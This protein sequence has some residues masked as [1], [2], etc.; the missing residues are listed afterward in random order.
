MADLGLGATGIADILRELTDMFDG[1]GV[2]VD[3]ERFSPLKLYTCLLSGATQGTPGCNVRGVWDG[4]GLSVAVTMLVEEFKRRA[5]VA[6]QSGKSREPA[7]AKAANPKAAKLKSKSKPK[8]KPKPKP[9]AAKPK[10]KVAKPKA[11]KPKAAQPKPKAKVAKPKAAKAKAKEEKKSESESE[12]DAKPLT[13]YGAV[14]QARAAGNFKGAAA[15]G[16]PL[17]EAARALMAQS[18]AANPRTKAVKVKAAKPKTKAKAKAK[19]KPKA[20]YN[21]NTNAGRLAKMPRVP[22]YPRY[23]RQLLRYWAKHPNDAARLRVLNED[24]NQ[25]ADSIGLDPS[26]TRLSGGDL[27]FALLKMLHHIIRTFTRGTVDDGEGFEP[28]SVAVG[29]C[30]VNTRVGEYG[31]DR[32]TLNVERVR[33]LPHRS[34]DVRTAVLMVLQHETVHLLQE[35]RLLDYPNIDQHEEEFEMYGGIDLG[36]TQ[37]LRDMAKHIYGHDGVAFLPNTCCMMG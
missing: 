20:K 29:P 7:K 24:M 25:Y 33:G 36:H 16:T 2:D 23:A 9:K 31:Q 18:R 32:I 4:D 6:S 26:M 15:K 35:R 21:Y 17:Y 1:A 22:Y 13:F 11:A 8:P 27:E 12:S 37:A 10:A 30:L 14:A 28:W 34:C 5:R 19:A 3:D